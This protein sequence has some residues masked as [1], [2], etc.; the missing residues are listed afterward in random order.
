MKSDAHDDRTF[1]MPALA[2]KLTEVPADVGLAVSLVL[3]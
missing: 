1:T 2:P 3:C